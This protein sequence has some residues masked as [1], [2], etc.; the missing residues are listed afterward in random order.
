MRIA[1]ESI[2]KRCT[3]SHYWLLG[4]GIF[5]WIAVI[6]CLS[7]VPPVSRD[8]LTHH[9]RVPQ[10]YLDHG[11]M[12]E[13]P[14]IEFSYYPMNLDMLYLISLWWG[15]DIIPKYIHFAFALLTAGLLFQYLRQRLGLVYAS[16]GAFFFLSIPII[17]KLSIN[18]YVDL[19]LAFFSTAT[20]LQLFRWMENTRSKKHLVL[21]GLWCGLAMGTKYNGLICFILTAG[22]IPFLLKYS[23]KCTKIVAGNQSIDECP[24]S[25]FALLIFSTMA[26][27]VF[28]PW[29]IRNWIWTANPV[30]PL[31]DSLFNP[32]AVTGSSG[33]TPFALRHQI[34]G[35]SIWQI[36]FIPLR[37][38][39]NG[40][41][42]NP[43][44]FDGQLSPFLLILPLFAIIK[45]DQ[46]TFQL[47]HEK[48]FLLY[49]S[50]FT[51]LIVFFKHDMRVRYIAPAI[52]ALVLLSTMGL[53]HLFSVLI[54][55]DHLSTRR[56]K[57]GLV[58][59]VCGVLAFNLPYLFVQW[60]QVDPFS[61]LTG[62]LS[63]DAYIE[64]RRPEYSLYRYANANLST[65][66]RI[67]ALFL[68]NRGYY[69]ERSI[70]FD[71]AGFW[72]ALDS[73][74]TAEAVADKLR[75]KGFSHIMIN[76]GLFVPW[77]NLNLNKEALSRMV[78]FFRE[79]ARTL[80][81][82]DTGYL[83]LEIDQQ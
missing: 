7:S 23:T 77:T 39:W 22:A 1:W 65:D 78:T 41:D 28:S 37:I 70:I 14:R 61:Y 47:R 8:A 83:L 16:F 67:L 51:I 69:C 34:Y 2:H 5:L 44:Q 40:Q 4:G 29:M 49:F 3:Q 58:A 26:L 38:F 42:N 35:E 27:A 80:I 10:L 73:A 50:V 75:S 32:N 46:N 15:N 30:Y 12:V 54:P 82:T 53:H 24:T 60:K 45:M 72:E 64:K 59:I 56:V 55:A 25:G 66:V 13:L 11:A 18:V 19:G 81:R 68:G 20:I 48:L 17:V 43:Q 63:R 31:F 33:F 57:W 21:A 71:I 52:P 76:Q 36:L 6:V 74:D 79:E 62:A 9:L